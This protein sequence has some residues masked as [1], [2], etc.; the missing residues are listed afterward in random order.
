MSS[1]HEIAAEFRTTRTRLAVAG[2][3]AATLDAFTAERRGDRRKSIIF[4]SIMLFAVTFAVV[5]MLSIILW[6]VIKGWSRLDSNLI[7]GAP[8]TVDPSKSG[9]KTAVLGTLWVIGGVIF[10]IVPIGVGAAIYLEEFAD[11]RH[12]WNR[13]IELNIQNL[14]GVPSIVF[15]ILGL[16]FIVRDP[17]GFGFVPAAG[18]LTLALLVLPTVILS[19]REAIRAVPQSISDGSLALGATK[20]QTIRNQVLPNAL[21]GIL[22][23]LILSISRAI[24]EAAPLLLVG[25]ATFV[26]YNPSMFK[27]GY[28]TLP[29]QIFTYAG[30]PQDEFRIVAAAGVVLM[31][32]VVLLLNSMAIW[33]R[34]RFEQRW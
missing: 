8:S 18:A 32:A 16:S 23:G 27:T 12:W 30:R 17:L 26:T 20:W 1:S 25:A 9:F 15:G 33:L 29:V 19:S 13:L 34:R 5:A 31:V 3:R 11:R 21:P 10:L 2:A 14:A 28:S 7:F 6:A 24:G 4:M 22:T